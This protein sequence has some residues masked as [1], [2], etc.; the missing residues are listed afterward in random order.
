LKYHLISLIALAA[1]A[2]FLLPDP[3]ERQ[4]VAATKRIDQVDQR[5]TRMER[6]IGISIDM[7]VVFN[8][9]CLIANP[10]LLEP[11]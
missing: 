9:F 5:L 11:A 6:D 8:S 4:E 3:A 10:P 7:L 2:S 1:I